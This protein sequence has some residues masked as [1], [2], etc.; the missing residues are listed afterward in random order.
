M[1]G[2]FSFQCSPNMAVS[3]QQVMTSKRQAPP[4]LLQS[5][6]PRSPLRC[7]NRLRLL[8]GWLVDVTLVW[9]YQP[10]PT[11]PHL[12]LGC[13]AKFS[14][15]WYL[16]TRQQHVSVSE[17][18]AGSPQRQNLMIQHSSMLVCRLGESLLAEC[19]WPL[20]LTDTNRLTKERRKKMFIL[21]Y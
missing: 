3:R 9:R 18:A 6:R 20:A 1:D 21:L 10:P 15:A 12:P 14:P 16:Q 8:I 4:T 19:D 7:R 2:V 5:A 17:S 13:G 11:S